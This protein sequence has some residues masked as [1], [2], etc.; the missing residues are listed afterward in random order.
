MQIQA[1]ALA[2]TSPDMTAA[3]GF[4]NTAIV[5]ARAVYA[6]VD[7][8]GKTCGGIYCTISCRG[9]LRAVFGLNELGGYVVGYMP[10]GNS[11][12]YFAF[13]HSTV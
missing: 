8:L 4:A 7:D 6:D 2:V 3:S 10:K 13:Y 11:C 5:V 9:C 12:H 1:S